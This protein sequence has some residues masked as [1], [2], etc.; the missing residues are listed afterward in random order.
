M[1]KNVKQLSHWLCI[2]CTISS[3]ID[4]YYIR[5]QVIHYQNCTSVVDCI[6]GHNPLL[7]LYPH[8]LQVLP[9]KGR[10]SFSSSFI[11]P[12]LMAFPWPIGCSRSQ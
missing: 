11:W 1:K 6:D 12:G 3:D 5:K 10:G 8:H 7:Y 9:L 4:L 2:C